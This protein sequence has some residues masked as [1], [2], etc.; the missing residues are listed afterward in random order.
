MVKKIIFLRLLLFCTLPFFATKIHSQ[1]IT[2]YCINNGG[3]FSGTIEWSIGETVSI[4]NLIAPGFSL[5]TGVL[6]PMTTVVTSINEFGPKVFGNQII[7]GPNPT[8]NFLHVNAKMNEF[9]NLSIQLLD[10]KSSIILTEEIGKISNN[11]DKNIYL[12]NYPSGIFY[13]KVFFKTIAGKEKVGIYKI[14]KL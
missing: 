2:P 13:L 4:T 3:G 9:G 14:I 7:I 12:E 8:S 10:A 11:Y 6:Q 1:S 5:N